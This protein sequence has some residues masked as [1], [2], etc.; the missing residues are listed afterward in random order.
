M[1]FPRQHSIVFYTRLDQRAVYKRMEAICIFGDSLSRGVVFDRIR[2]R[3]AFLKDSFVNLFCRKMRIR[4]INY[5]K[6]GCTIGKGNRLMDQH[7]AEIAGFD[8]TVL[9]FGGNDCD[10]DW[11]RVAEA[12]EAEHLPKTPL[13]VFAAT[14]A[15]LID[16]TRAAGGNPVLLNLPPIHPKRYFSWV[17]RGL[18]G[19]NILKW[20]GGSEE[21]IYRWHELYNMQVCQLAGEK[22]V[23]LIDIRSVFLA[24]KDYGAYLCVDGIHPNEAGH[25]LISQAIEAAVAR[26]M[27]R[28]AHDSRF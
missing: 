15:K 2:E 12:P 10:F 1:T 18:N 17:S 28:E 27:P 8:F 5:A 6:F 4:V 13:D 26:L 23:P 21:Y 14:Y 19:D 24:Q 16:K 22:Q 20:L 7:Q 3:Y 9:E 11:A 25:Q